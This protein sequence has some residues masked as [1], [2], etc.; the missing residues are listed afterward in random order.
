[1]V[2]NIIST[3]ENGMLRKQEINKQ[4]DNVAN[5]VGILYYMILT[6]SH[7]LLS[8]RYCHGFSGCAIMFIL[9]KSGRHVDMSCCHVIEFQGN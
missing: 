7:L 2:I 5:S 4:R 6:L 8:H 3:S 1:M 9:H